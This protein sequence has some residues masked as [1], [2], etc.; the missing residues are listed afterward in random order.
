MQEPVKKPDV[1]FFASGCIDTS[2]KKAKTRVPSHQDVTPTRLSSIGQPHLSYHPCP[3]VILG[4]RPRAKVTDTRN[5]N[6]PRCYVAD[7]SRWDIL[8]GRR[9]SQA[10]PK[11]VDPVG[12]R[13]IYLHRTNSFTVLRRPWAAAAI[14]RP[15]HG[16]VGWR[17]VHPRRIFNATRRQT[18][19]EHKLR[20]VL[21]NAN[22]LKSV[23]MSFRGFFFNLR[24]RFAAFFFEL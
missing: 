3:I 21:M 5:T 11:S 12:R 10:K 9:R 15:R 24:T 13:P 23:S 7:T 22:E 2:K 20:P 19:P 16:G 18:F 8:Q 14:V 17:V 4:W 1:V 6:D